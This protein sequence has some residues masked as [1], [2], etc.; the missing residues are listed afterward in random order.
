MRA[1]LCGAGRVS[2]PSKGGYIEPTHPTPDGKG[3][4]MP[5]H[6][7]EFILSQEE[8]ARIW[9]AAMTDWL[10]DRQKGYRKGPQE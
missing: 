5:L 2:D 3:V 6:K 7:D 10:R 1:D 9:H 4:Q 8:M